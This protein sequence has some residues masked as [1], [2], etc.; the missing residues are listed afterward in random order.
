MIRTK[1]ASD[2]TIVGH[3]HGIDLFFF[4]ALKCRLDLQ[5]KSI[6]R[7]I[8]TKEASHIGVVCSSLTK[9]LCTLHTLKTVFKN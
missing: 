3:Q 4:S 7:S 1:K 2:I 9:K 5:L 6:N 8:K